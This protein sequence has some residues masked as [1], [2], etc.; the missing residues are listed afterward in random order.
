MAKVA[1]RRSVAP[2]P[3]LLA[4][5][6]AYWPLSEASGN[7][8]ADAHSNGYDLTETGTLATDTGHIYAAAAD[9]DMTADNWL[10]RQYAN[11]ALI[12]FGAGDAFSLV[13]WCR[14]TAFTGGP[15]SP[16]YY[17][18]FCSLNY[19]SY[20]SGGYV[21]Q[22]TAAGQFYINLG[23]TMSDPVDTL[24]WHTGL[25]CTL[26]QWQMVAFTYDDSTGAAVARI[27]TNTA[28]TTN[29][30]PFVAASSGDF[31]VGGRGNGQYVYDGMIGPF[32]FFDKV[33][34][35][36]ELDWLYNGGVGRAYAEI[37]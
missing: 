18:I 25:S 21:F 37:A 1:V 15:D 19:G 23:N 24:G 14:P 31:Y 34:N 9:F 16:E 4:N 11:S 28:S 2:A 6:V 20:N 30:H 27:N 35:A 8:R 3:S 33:L 22:T 13:L 32:M 7:T 10:T 26:N 12:N 17:R 5:L 29:T 36:T